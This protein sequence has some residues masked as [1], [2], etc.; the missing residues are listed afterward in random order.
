MT[1]IRI[2]SAAGLALA[3]SACIAPPKFEPGD[4]VLVPDGP[5]AVPATPGLAPP[6]GPLTGLPLLRA[7]V[8]ATPL[9]PLP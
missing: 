9:T 6:P 2:L 1:I 3:L 8:S 4:R 7:P 5:V